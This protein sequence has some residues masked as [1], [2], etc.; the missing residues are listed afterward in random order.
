[1]LTKR[2]TGFAVAALCGGCGTFT[3][4]MTGAVNSTTQTRPTISVDQ[5]FDEAKNLLLATGAEDIT[6]A[7]GV[8]IYGPG[9][10]RWFRLRDGKW[11]SVRVIEVG[12]PKQLVIAKLVLGDKNTNHIKERYPKG[13]PEIARLEL[14]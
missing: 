13:Y 3:S 14:P 4:Q 2:L 1:M 5:P 9:E 8:I 11:L 12:E 6:H 10:Q 7:I